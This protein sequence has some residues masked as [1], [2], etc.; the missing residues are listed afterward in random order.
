MGEDFMFELR[1]MSD[2]VKEIVNVDRIWKEKT[3]ITN[4]VSKNRSTLSTKGAT[5][6]VMLLRNLEK[7][8]EIAPN[9]ISIPL[10]TGFTRKAIKH[11]LIYCTRIYWK[12]LT[13]IWWDEDDEEDM[14]LPAELDEYQQ[15]KRR[16]SRQ[17]SS[18]VSDHMKRQLSQSL[19]SD[20]FGKLIL[21]KSYTNED[22]ED[23]PSYQNDNFLKV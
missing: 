22:E 17:R 13:D 21:Q 5:R 4:T 9:D 10:L 15:R 23:E 12:V 6:I 11:S 2:V 14:A 16:H 3:N 1:D 18:K 20:L 8:S 19:N 7:E